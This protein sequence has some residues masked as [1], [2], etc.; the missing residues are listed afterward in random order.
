[1]QTA[2]NLIA[3]SAKFAAGMQQRQCRLHRRFA[4]F[5]MNIHRD[6]AS[7]I[8]YGNAAVR[9]NLHGDSITKTGQ[10]FINTVIDNFIYK[11][12]QTLTARGTDI[13]A[14]PA[15]HRLQPL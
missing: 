7:V 8:G 13:H 15:A 9:F 11:M 2:G 14:R 4:G 10:R 5:G 6:T 12:M 1:M 3:A